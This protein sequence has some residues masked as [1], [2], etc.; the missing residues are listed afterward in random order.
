MI[1]V[2][3]IFFLCSSSDRNNLYGRGCGN[4]VEIVVVMV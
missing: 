4:V 1:L 3:W 2:R